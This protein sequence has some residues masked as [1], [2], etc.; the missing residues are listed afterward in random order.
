[1]GLTTKVPFDLR[2]SFTNMTFYV[3]SYIS[4]LRSIDDDPIAHRADFWPVPT[5]VLRACHER[6]K[7]TDL[8]VTSIEVV[9]KLPHPIYDAF[10]TD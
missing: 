8:P 4:C 3:G 7:V 1:M 10:A 5:V 9:L 6:A 2:Q